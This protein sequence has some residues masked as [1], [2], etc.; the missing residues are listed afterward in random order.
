MHELAITRNIIDLVSEAAHGRR[1]AR[2]TLEIGRLSGVLPDA[3]TFCFPELA[4]G[5][6]AESADL[7]IDQIDGRARCATCR[8]EFPAGDLLVICC[9]GST[10]CRTIAGEELNV[11]SIEV[12]E[13]E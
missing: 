2:V 6:P 7:C 12:E 4:R 1:I 13:L 10:D 5:T 8:R 11:K 9:C 3:I